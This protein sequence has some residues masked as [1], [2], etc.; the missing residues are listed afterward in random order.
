[1]V[2]NANPREGPSHYYQSAP[3]KLTA[4]CRWQRAGMTRAQITRLPDARSE[5]GKVFARTI[6]AE[7]V[8]TV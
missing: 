2:D 8:S 7:S 4:A 5:I 1:M 6:L 3:Y